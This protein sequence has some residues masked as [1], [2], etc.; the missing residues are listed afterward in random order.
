MSGSFDNF[1]TVCNGNRSLTPALSFMAV[2]WY[3]YGAPSRDPHLRN[4]RLAE[5]FTAMMVVSAGTSAMQ[6]HAH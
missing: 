4:D 5:A 6:Q 1:A 3:V 2:G